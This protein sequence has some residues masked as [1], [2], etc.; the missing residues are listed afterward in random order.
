MLN[1]VNAE[2]IS[3]TLSISIV[4]D[5]WEIGRI[6]ALFWAPHQESNIRH[7]RLYISKYTATIGTS[8]TPMLSTTLCLRLGSL[9]CKTRTTTFEVFVSGFDIKFR[10]LMSIKIKSKCIRAMQTYLLFTSFFLSF[11]KFFQSL[12][13]VSFNLMN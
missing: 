10:T 4:E 1:V 9:S 3:I 11:T 7:I 5:D 8:N 6:L 13:L 2:K 12:L